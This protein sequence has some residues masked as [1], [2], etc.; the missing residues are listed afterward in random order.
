[1][2]RLLSYPRFKFTQ[3]DGT[4]AVGWKVASY[5]AGTSTP[6]ST[7]TDQSGTVVNANPTI[8]DGSGEAE[9]WLDPDAAYKIV[10]KDENDVVQWTVDDVNAADILAA[11]S[12]TVSGST[13]LQATT[14][15]TI[16]AS[17]QVTST[18]VTGTAPL[19]IA[20]TT[21]VANLNVDKLDDQDWASPGAIGSN[22]PST[23]VFT[24]LSGTSVA[25]R[26][27]AN[28]S[29]A[30]INVTSEEVTLS[31]SGTT[32]DSTANLLPADA[33]ILSVTACVTQTI[34]TA[35]DWKL[36]DG[37]TAARFT[38]AIATLVADTRV[39]GLAHMAG[40]ISTD[41]AG[42][43]QGAAAKVRITTTG[44]PGAGKIRI[45]VYSLVFVPPTS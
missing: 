17:G 38:G 22:T 44:T 6:L 32:T 26:S 33:I 10:L 7:Y 23:G 25:T 19:V 18:V 37:T 13:S 2:A 4:P 1:M 34:T 45:T 5:Q 9:I 20:S 3:D 42:P 30:T 29:S 39:A 15:T 12:L 11:T 24:S 14:A 27:A 8:L 28:G 21:K 40:G 16:S 43:T 31:T 36:G 35:T 41:A